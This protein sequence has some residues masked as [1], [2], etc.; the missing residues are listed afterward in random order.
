MQRETKGGI[1]CAVLA[2]VLYA[3]NAPFSKQLL[4]SLPPTLTAGFLYL[5]AGAGMALIALIRRIRKTAGRESKLT[6]AELPYTVAM[7]VLDI[8][9]P[10]CLM[11][12][13]RSTPA[14]SA[15]LLNNFEIVATALI[16]WVVF[17]ERIR[18]RLW[19]GILCVTA[20]CAL[21][22]LEN[23][24]GMHFS[25]GSL[26]VLLAAV[27]WGLENNCTRKLSDKDPME[28]VLLKGLFSGAGSLI[29]G[30]CIGERVALWSDVP[31]AL[32]LGF[33]AYGLSIFFY[34]YAQRKLGA[35]RTSTFY[36]LAPFVSVFL[37]LALFREKPGYAFPAAL[38]LMALG[39]WLS[40]CEK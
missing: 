23:L 39:T 4:R 33:V 26:L 15:A 35:A 16:A 36:A 20:A 29:T 30:L 17:R 40:A 18:V 3:V 7:I 10:V 2:A 24:Q 5:G 13:L 32:A 9:A 11:F 1:F 6:R 28:I 37:S 38:A 22:S 31:A 34:V 21:L 14:A 19:L 8:A 12:G 27:C 25:K